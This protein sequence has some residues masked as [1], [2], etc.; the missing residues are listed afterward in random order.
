MKA[1][2]LFHAWSVKFSKDKAHLHPSPEAK[3]ILAMMDHY[4]DIHFHDRN[5]LRADMKAALPKNPGGVHEAER[6]GRE[7]A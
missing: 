6:G 2:D 5:A 4:N 1:I 7:S 3:T